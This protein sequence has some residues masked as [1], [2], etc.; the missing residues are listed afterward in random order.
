MAL[1]SGQRHGYSSAS[2][3]QDRLVTG[4]AGLAGQCRVRSEVCVEDGGL[5]VSGVHCAFCVTNTEPRC[6][7]SAMRE[8]QKDGTLRN[9]HAVKPGDGYE[10]KLTVAA[11]RVAAAIVVLADGC[12]AR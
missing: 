9:R 3:R 2:V 6:G 12:V 4:C 5:R 7:H 1:P 11:W 8:R 10:I